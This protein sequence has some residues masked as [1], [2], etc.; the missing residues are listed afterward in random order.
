MPNL[1]DTEGKIR[2]QK[3]N[4]EEQKCQADCAGINDGGKL[5]AK[6]SSCRPGA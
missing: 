5:P 6:A 2:D 1:R 4:M 3:E